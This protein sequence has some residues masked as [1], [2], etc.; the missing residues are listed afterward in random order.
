MGI[1]KVIKGRNKLAEAVE[2]G[3][4]D[5]YN[6]WIA[7]IQGRLDRAKELAARVDEHSGA[8]AA[9]YNSEQIYNDFKDDAKARLT[10]EDPTARIPQE[11]YEQILK[12]EEEV[13]KKSEQEIHA[14]I[15]VHD[16][17]PTL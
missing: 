5:W 8:Y 16:N 11:M 2:R 1:L 17:Q 6:G 9:F 10:V 12:L 4:Q 13:L 15:K 7:R 3:R 14:L